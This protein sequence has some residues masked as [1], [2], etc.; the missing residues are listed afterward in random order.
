MVLPLILMLFQSTP[1]FSGEG[2][3]EQEYT[4]GDWTAFQSTPAFSGEGTPEAARGRQRQ[5]VSIHPRLFRRGN[6]F[7]RCRQTPCPRF[8][9][10]PAFSGEGTTITANEYKTIAFQSTPAFSGE[11]TPAASH[12][13]ATKRQF[14]STPAFSGEGTKRRGKNHIHK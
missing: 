13:K 4:A 3:G 9:S 8:Q 1:A 6:F 5:P 11:G 10:T 14:Q 2:T 12:H 7:P